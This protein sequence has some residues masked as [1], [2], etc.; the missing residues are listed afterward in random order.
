MICGDQHEMKIIIHA[1]EYFFFFTHF[2]LLEANFLE[3][4]SNHPNCSCLAN[5]SDNISVQFS[6]FYPLHGLPV[7]FCINFKVLLLTFRALHGQY[8]CT[9]PPSYSQAPRL[10][11][12]LKS[13]DQK[14][15]FGDCA[16]QV[17]APKLWSA[18]PLLH[19]FL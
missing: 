2:Y 7:K 13:C 3:P 10:H 19:R 14:P 16:F 15:C 5:I 9:P 6:Q 17:V 1:F 12:A 11:Q 4:S 8:H 18:H